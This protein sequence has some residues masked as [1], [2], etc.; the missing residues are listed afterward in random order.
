MGQIKHCHFLSFVASTVYQSIGVGLERQHKSMTVFALAKGL[1]RAVI[2]IDN[3]DV[4]LIFFCRS[5][6]DTHFKK[7]ILLTYKL[8]V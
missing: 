5:I 4:S 8:N 7:S 6:I 3:I 1:T 2:D